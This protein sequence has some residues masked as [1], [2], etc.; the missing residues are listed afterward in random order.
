M[1]SALGRWTWR[2]TLLQ[3]LLI[4]PLFYHLAYFV[5][6]IGMAESKQAKG[7]ET[8]WQLVDKPPPYDPLFEPNN[9]PATDRKVSARFHELPIETEFSVFGFYDYGPGIKASL[10]DWLSVPTWLNSVTQPKVDQV[11]YTLRISKDGHL[12]G[13]SNDSCGKAD[14]AGTVDWKAGIVRF[15]K[16]YGANNLWANWSYIGNFAQEGT[17]VVG[18]W[19]S[20]VALKDGTGVYFSPRGRFDMWLDIKGRSN[21]KILTEQLRLRDGKPTSS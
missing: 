15:T 20:P 11:T 12:T 5:I 18:N 21:D 14:I 7:E 2:S 10:P 9:V 6:F 8:E 3:L 4:H 19:S 1:V 16:K 13:S 17:H